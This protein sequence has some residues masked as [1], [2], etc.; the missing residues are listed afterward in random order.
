[1]NDLSLHII[2][3][4]QNSLSAGA[5]FIGLTVDENL[6]E[7]KITIKIEDNG[8]GMTQDQVSRLT[9]P[10]FTSRTTRRVG[11]GIPLFKQSAN[12]SGG[13]LKVESVPGKGTTV[14]AWFRQS[15]IDCPPM[16]DVANAFILMLSAN[17]ALHFIFKYLYNSQE[18][19]F[20]SEEVREILENIPFNDASIIRVLTNMIRENLNDLKNGSNY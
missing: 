15:N 13:D 9:D 1:M 14:T 12:Q 4:I 10:F 2:D 20:D 8:K 19:I 17:P 16:G 5:S 6:K 3:I 11:M 18:Y 7:D